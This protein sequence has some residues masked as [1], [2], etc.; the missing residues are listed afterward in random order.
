L[1]LVDWRWSACFDS[2]SGGEMATAAPIREESTYLEHFFNAKDGIRLFFR[3][4]QVPAPKGEVALVHG[5]AEHCGRYDQLAERLMAAGYSVAAMD[6]RGHGQSG[7]RRAHIDRF[8]EYLGDVENFLDE[9]VRVGL[10]RPPLLLGHSQGGLIAARFGELNGTRLQAVILS[11][12]FLGLAVRVPVAKAMMGRVVSR[13]L[14]TFSMPSGLDPA[15]IS[16][17]EEKVRAYAS[18]PLVSHHVTARWF[19]EIAQAQEQA[20]AEAGRLD[21]P[22]LVLAA[23]DDRV[24]SLETTE[25]FFAAAASS[26]KQ[27]KIYPNQYHEIFNEVEREQTFGDLINWIDALV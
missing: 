7:G 8:E 17:D 21:L 12:P 11:S 13:W 20:L 19:T 24:V 23:G 25:R 10:T 15:W 26:R 27:M 6:Y 22:L 18:D 16:H 4:W 1:L 2:L 5:F 3:C 9:M 14:P